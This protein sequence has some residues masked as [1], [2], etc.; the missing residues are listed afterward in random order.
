MLN[1]PVIVFQ[2]RGV[3]AVQKLQDVVGPA[4]REEALSNYPHSLRARY[5]HLSAS[6]LYVAT[7]ETVQEV[8]IFLCFLLKMGIYL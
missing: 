3:D 5:S 7:E 6:N 8:K 2:L 4:D 1:G